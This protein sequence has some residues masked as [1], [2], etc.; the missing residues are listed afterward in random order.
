MNASVRRILAKWY[1]GDVG[2]RREEG[3]EADRRKGGEVD[4][5]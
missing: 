5:Y 2:G 3:K 1:R 4:G